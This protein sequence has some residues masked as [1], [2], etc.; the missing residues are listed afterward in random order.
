[1][2]E[3]AV[4][5]SPD[6]FNVEDRTRARR[7]HAQQSPQTLSFN[8]RTRGRKRLA[9]RHSEPH[10]YARTTGFRPVF[11]DQRVL[12][13][14]RFC[15]AGFRAARVLSKAVCLIMMRPK[16]IN[17]QR[18]IPKNVQAGVR[19]D[20]RVTRKGFSIEMVR[21]TERGMGREG[22]ISETENGIIPSLVCMSLR[23]T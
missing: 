21:E 9:G 20:E 12:T 22:E 5:S 18:S 10:G 2:V 19:C 14:A 11:R 3:A 8:A 1:M 13:K 4:A 23:L 17:N 7:V 16:V 6:Q 15:S